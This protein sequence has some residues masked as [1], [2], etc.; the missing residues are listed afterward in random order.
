VALLKT[1][2]WKQGL[3]LMREAVK[4]DPNNATLK[5]ALDDALTQ[6]PVEFGGKGKTRTVKHP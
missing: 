6:A 1:G 5:A 4:R 3:E 2:D